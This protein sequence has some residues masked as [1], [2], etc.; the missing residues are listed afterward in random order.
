MRWYL[1]AIIF[2]SACQPQIQEAV[3]LGAELS[4]HYI[5]IGQGDSTLIILPNNETVLIDCGK[6]NKGEDIIT[7]LNDIGV[8]DIDLLIATHPDADHIG[9]CDEVIQGF[10]VETVLTNGQ[11]KNTRVY[12]DFIA[13]AQQ[14]D[15]Q[16]LTKDSVVTLDP[17]AK[18]SL[19]V[20]Y[21]AGY[22]D[23]S[24][25]NSIVVKLEY[26][27]KFLFTGDCEF[28]CESKLEEIDIDIYKVGH[29]GSKSSSNSKFL[30]KITPEI[31]II[32]A[33][34][35]NRYHHPHPSAIKRIS[36]HTDNIFGTYDHGTIVV[37]TDGAIIEVF[38]SELLLWKKF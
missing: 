29:H 16:K 7:Y 22:D 28:N 2:L 32:S 14:R 17:S 33:G 4:V 24:N 12:R 5:D 15:L 35:D 10:D 26:G 38:D 13:A 8:D 23:N 3:P 20:T 11:S 37:K 18:L 6:T 21:E 34:R 36:K 19:L 30:S 1:V 27:A 9:G 25:E 31:A